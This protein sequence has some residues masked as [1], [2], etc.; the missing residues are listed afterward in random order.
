MEVFAFQAAL[1]CVTCGE[2]AIL[3]CRGKGLA[4]NGDSGDFPQGPYSNGGG[5]ADT[6][7]ACDVCGTFLE[8]PLT[9]DGAAYVRERLGSGKG[10]S[11]VLATWASF[12]GL[13]A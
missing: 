1:L 10:D 6:P 5:E 3:T 8:N 2:Q 12:Y 11:D 13:D 7:Q 9:R 4:D